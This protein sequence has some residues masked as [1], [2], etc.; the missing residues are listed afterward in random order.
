MTK[1]D[2]SEELA[3]ESPPTATAGIEQSMADLTEQMAA[4]TAAWTR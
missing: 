4:L 2:H 3:T 1:M